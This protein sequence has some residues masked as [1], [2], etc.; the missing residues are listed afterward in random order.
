MRARHDVVLWNRTGYIALAARTIRMST[1]CTHIY[2]VRLMVVL[3]VKAILV[4]SCIHVVHLDHRAMRLGDV[5]GSGQNGAI[6]NDLRFV[7]R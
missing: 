1:L 3:P 4:V 5:D 6:G 2:E 7:I